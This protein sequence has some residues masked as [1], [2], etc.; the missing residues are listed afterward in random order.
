MV[1]SNEVKG[2]YMAL[3]FWIPHPVLC[4]EYFGR[5]NKHAKDGNFV[6]WAIIFSISSY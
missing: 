5:P 6:L 2:F 3:Q 1:K 4:K